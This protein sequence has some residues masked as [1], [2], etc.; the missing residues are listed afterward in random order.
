MEY[1]TCRTEAHVSTQ[2]APLSS[3]E[4]ARVRSAPEAVLAPDL[5]RLLPET[6][7]AA[8]WHC[9]LSGLVWVQRSGPAAGSVV[10]APLRRSALDRWLAVAFVH[11]EDSPVGPY[12]ELLAAFLLRRGPRL[13]LHTPFMAV[14]SLPS[15]RAG[16]ANWALPKTL[17]EFGDGYGRTGAW[18]AAAHGWSVTARAR[19]R[20]PRL[21]LR[22]AVHGAQVRPDQTV[23]RYRATISGSARLARVEVDVTA[24]E[25][26]A[27]WLPSGRHVG[28]RLSNAS[29]TMS[30]SFAG[31]R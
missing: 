18:S 13:V 19:A 1:A 4:L 21:P 16:R 8:P 28:L 31:T 2:L 30:P 7:P 6:A 3:N 11:Y 9:T 15:L 20:G 23:G 22:A 24:Q 14:D 27:R 29:L 10:P 17:A 26:L 25:S 5:V 12:S